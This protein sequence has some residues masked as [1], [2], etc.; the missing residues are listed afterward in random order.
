MKTRY[1]TLLILPF[2]C[3]SLTTVAQKFITALQHNGATQIFYGQNSFVEAYN[4]SVKGDTLN[5][6]AGYFNAPASI[7]K[8]VKIIGSGHFPDSTGVVVKRTKILSGLNIAKGAD[9]LHLEGLYIEGNILYANE[10]SISYVRVLRCKFYNAYSNSS[11]VLAGRNF[12]SFEECYCPG[13]ISFSGYGDNLLIKHCIVSQ[14]SDIGGN[15]IIDGNIIL[16]LD[17]YSLMN[18]NSSLIRNNIMTSRNSALYGC[19]Q[20]VFYNNIMF[21]D[22]GTNSY[23]NN[24][25]LISSS[26]IFVNPSEDFYTS[27]YHLKNP[28]KYIG[29]DGTQIGLYGGTTPFKEKGL[30]SNPQIVKKNIGEQTDA[31]GNL[32]VNVTVKAQ[33]N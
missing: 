13:S 32:N 2:F 16:R 29:T 24:Y 20:N 27:D 17:G 26:E 19:T 14:I 9:S 25:A 5:L 15:S 30:P 6:S 23:S 33:S 4:V 3:F 31:N 12:C 18:V 10:S 22:F 28:E 21:S 11:S 1:F 8:G 7:G